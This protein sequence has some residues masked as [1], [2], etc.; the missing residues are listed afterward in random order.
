VRER[1]GFVQRHS[2]LI[3]AFG[4]AAAG[5]AVVFLLIL[6]ETGGRFIYNLDDAYIHLAI[7]KHIVQNGVWGVTP[8]E[9]S[10]S[11]SSILWPV[12]LAA[13]FKIFGVRE[14]LPLGIAVAASAILMTILY[15]EWT[16]RESHPGWTLA[17]LI[18]WILFLPLWPIL[19]NGME[20]MLQALTAVAL[21]AVAV[22][23]LAAE[24]P[25]RLL[26][27]CLLG[28]LA[29]AVRYEGCFIAASVC[30]LLAF[31]GRWKA[32]IL[33]GL[34]AALPVVLY[35]IYSLGQGWSFLPNS[36]LV[37]HSGIDATSLAALWSVL[38][39]PFQ[40]IMNIGVL[41]L[42]VWQSLAVIVLMM[43][44]LRARTVPL[45]GL[46]DDRLLPAVLFL[47]VAVLHSLGIASDWFFRYQAY[48][49]TL[50]IWAIGCVGIPVVDW[51]TL[52]HHAAS[53]ITA[54][55]AAILVAVPL[56]S[57]AVQA[58]WE[59]PLA[60]RNIW[61]QQYQMG[62]F[63]REYYPQ[64][65]VAANDIG[66]IDFLNDIHLMDLTG[67][68]SRSAMRAEI[69]GSWH[70]DVAGTLDALTSAEGVQIAVIYDN[71]FDYNPA[72]GR[73]AVPAQWERVAAWTIPDNIVCGGATV[74]WY[75]VVPEGANALRSALEQFSA[76]LPAGV[77]VQQYPL[78]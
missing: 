30:V 2:S 72:T 7:A 25:G 60:S 69:D 22:H 75:A 65:R 38:A 8:Y 11:S 47:M 32:A 64:G 53:A 45:R 35:G 24:K 67:L 54:A 66:A 23:Y 41:Q 21:G 57:S 17:L 74:T 16:Q 18:G 55:C 71:W 12:L 27:L 20:T 58:I 28:A 39:R 52:R 49:N 36:V 73:A 68:A 63:L 10:S 44:L 1:P 51:A 5:A 26:P 61:Q 78:P 50:G 14:I 6:R 19:F 29:S 70:R 15:R 43:L 42:P 31:R 4:I 37:K 9:F 46:W 34:S 3:A 56:G 59:T 48:L 76:S 62:L 13:V 77:T 33:V 40:P